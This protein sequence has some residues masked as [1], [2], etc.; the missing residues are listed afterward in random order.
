MFSVPARNIIILSK[1][2]A[3]PP[4]GGA[5]NFNAC[6]KNPNDSHA[7]SS[8]NPKA[9]SILSWIAVSWILIDPPP[10]SSPFNTKSYA[11]DLTLP[12]SDST[13][14]KSSSIGAVN[15]WW[16]ALNLS[17]SSLYSKNGNSV[18]HVKLNSFL[19]LIKIASPSS[20]FIV[21]TIAFVTSSVKNLAIEDF[22]SP[23]LSW[24]HA[25]P[26]AL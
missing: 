25:R 19:S 13:N 2:N 7:L 5:P 18:T 12:G 15:G 20:A 9:L 14:S 1:P 26:F 23:S 6:N 4:C 8:V 24:I 11:L 22:T 3:N 17:S 16:Q 10:N 21:L